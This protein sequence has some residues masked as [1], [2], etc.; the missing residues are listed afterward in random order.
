MGK[1]DA[2][3]TNDGGTPLLDADTAHVP[4]AR[5]DVHPMRRPGMP[6]HDPALYDQSTEDKPESTSDPKAHSEDVRG[7]K[8]DRS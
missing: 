5:E 8:R 2:V 4:E 1:D 7:G 3:T 6:L